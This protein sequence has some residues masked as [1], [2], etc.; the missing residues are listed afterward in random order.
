L[1]S[2]TKSGYVIKMFAAPP[3]SRGRVTRY[4]VIAQPQRFGK[5]DKRSF[6]T[7]ESG[8]FHATPE[9]R[10]PTIQDPVL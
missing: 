1:A 5:D 8:A 2:G 7:D 10:A 9:N 4:T 3:D 6:F